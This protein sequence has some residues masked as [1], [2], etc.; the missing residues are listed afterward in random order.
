M[1]LPLPW[2]GA[3]PARFVGHR[4]HTKPCV[5]ILLPPRFV[6]LVLISIWSWLAYGLLMA[7]ALWRYAL[8]G[9]PSTSLGNRWEDRLGI[10]SGNRLGRESWD[11]LGR[12]SGDRLGKENGD[13]SGRESGDRSGRGSGD[14]L[15]RA[16]GGCCPCPPLGWLVDSAFD[17]QV[18]GFGQVF[19]PILLSGFACA[20]PFGPPPH[21]F[22]H[23]G[24]LQD[25][26][27]S[28]FQPAQFDVHFHEI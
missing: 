22:I 23:Q 25:A 13:R 19:H 16:G 3:L 26:V 17:Q 10:G 28:G 11:R 8:A 1:A 14:R 5:L 7:R 20:R 24:Q 9:R 27:Q 2:S 4:N 21:D 6:V 18:Q 12:E 15:E